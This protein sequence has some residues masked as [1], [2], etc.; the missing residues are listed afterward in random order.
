MIRRVGAIGLTGSV[1]A[2]L[3]AVH[4]FYLPLDYLVDKA[5]QKAQIDGLIEVVKSRIGL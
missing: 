2:A 3:A 4:V 1:V 5:V